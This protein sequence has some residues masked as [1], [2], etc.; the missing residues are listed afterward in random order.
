MSKEDGDAH[1]IFSIIGARNSVGVN[2]SA[3]SVT[4]IRRGRICIDVLCSK[5]K[6]SSSPCMYNVYYLLDVHAFP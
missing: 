3:K 4:T 1:L 5:E 2:I 6:F